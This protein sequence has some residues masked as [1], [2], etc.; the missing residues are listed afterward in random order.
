M[1]STFAMAGLS[2]DSGPCSKVSLF[3]SFFSFLLWK[4]MNSSVSEGVHL[5]VHHVV[6]EASLRQV[7]SLNSILDSLAVKLRSL[8]LKILVGHGGIHCFYIEHGNVYY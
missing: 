4:N 5:F 7:C 2:A 3:S 1:F 6:W 8:T